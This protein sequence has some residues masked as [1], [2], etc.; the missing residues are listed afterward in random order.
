VNVYEYVTIRE[1]NRMAQLIEVGGVEGIQD[2]C[3]HSVMHCLLDAARIA[4]DQA[5]PGWALAITQLAAAG[6][7]VEM[8]RPPEKPARKVL[9]PRRSRTL[10]PP[11]TFTLDDW[12]RLNSPP[13]YPSG[14]SRD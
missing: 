12:R 10:A 5:P 9:V 8:R 7:S 6:V 14:P 3:R 4:G 11:K 13:L 1:A 2:R